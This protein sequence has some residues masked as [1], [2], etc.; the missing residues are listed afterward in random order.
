MKT[1]DICKLIFASLVS[2]LS[3]CTLV[4]HIDMR[5]ILGASGL[6]CFMFV[7][8]LILKLVKAE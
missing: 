1:N 5:L 3:L 8:E 6:F 4:R 7:Y 2:I